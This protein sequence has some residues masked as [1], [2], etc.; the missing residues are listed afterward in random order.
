MYA[1]SVENFRRPKEEVDALMDLAMEKFAALSRESRL[2]KEKGVR[3]RILG[4]L[5]MLPLNVREA[6][7]EAMLLTKEYS[8]YT[9]NV[10][11]PY[12]SRHEILAV[13]N[14]FLKDDIAISDE[15]KVASL[16]D[17]RVYTAGGKNL[18]CLIRTSGEC[19][20]SE[21]LTW[22]VTTQRPLMFFINVLWPDLSVWHLLLI[23]MRYH[24]H[25]PNCLPI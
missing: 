13:T 25:R 8:N 5:E 6:A 24:N 15:G 20:L 4:E 18:E 9:L 19:R 23:I 2:I 16:I 3:I 1:F 17:S 7:Q 10:C 14:S 21:F 22:Q 12:T 11:F